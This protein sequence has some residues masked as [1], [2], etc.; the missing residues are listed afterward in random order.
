MLL[1]S[2]VIKVGALPEHQRD[3]G[4]EECLI[5]VVSS[6]R[7]TLG[8]KASELTSRQLGPAR[9][10]GE[11]TE[12]NPSTEAPAAAQQPARAKPTRSPSGQAHGY[13]RASHR[14]AVG[15][16]ALDSMRQ[17]SEAFTAGSPRSMATFIWTAINTKSGSPRPGRRRTRGANNRFLMTFSLPPFINTR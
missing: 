9:E 10:A 8:E 11:R 5:T 17:C 6:F 12:R 15:L 4:I 1:R 7:Q 3:E 14:L 2:G 16:R 13:D